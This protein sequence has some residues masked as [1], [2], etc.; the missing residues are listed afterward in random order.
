M[1]SKGWNRKTIMSSLQTL[2]ELRLVDVETHGSFPRFEKQYLL[3]ERGVYVAKFVRHLREV[4]R[5]SLD[6]KAEDFSRLP[7]R[8][9]PILIYL[10]SRGYKGI[11][12]MIEDLS[13]SPHQAYRCLA[14]MESMG[15]LRRVEHCREKR[16]V[17]F[18]R[19]SEKGILVAVAVDALDRA[20]KSPPS[21]GRHRQ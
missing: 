1:V 16:T 3:S 15:I 5:F 2:R 6:M 4:L 12:R 9:M 8:C 19:L 21:F 13:I 11:S 18:F 17:S 7:K 10:L 14:S 20:L